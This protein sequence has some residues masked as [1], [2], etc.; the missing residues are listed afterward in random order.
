MM[1]WSFVS[2]IL[3]QGIIII[4]GTLEQDKKKQKQKKNI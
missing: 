3:G 4:Q 1:R 2:G